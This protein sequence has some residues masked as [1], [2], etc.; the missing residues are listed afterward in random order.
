[1]KELKFKDVAHFYL[2]VKVLIT[3]NR[4]SIH[5]DKVATGEIAVMDAFVLN[6]YLTN[7][8]NIVPIL[9]PLSKMSEIDFENYLKLLPLESRNIPV[10]QDMHLCEF[11]TVQEFHFLCSRGY[12]VF[13]LPAEEFIEVS[14]TNRTEK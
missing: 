3:E 11:F 13:N 12:N 1:M 4:Y 9:I 10:R 8:M 5:S 2:G 6:G 14:P 7:K